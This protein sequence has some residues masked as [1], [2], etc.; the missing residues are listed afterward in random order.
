MIVLHNPDWQ[1][2]GRSSSREGIRATELVHEKGWSKFDLLLGMSERKNGLNTT[3]EYST[4]LFTPATVERIVGHFRTLAESAVA[5]SRT[6]RSRGSRC[7][8]DERARAHLL[9]ALERD[10]GD[11][12]RRPRRSRSCSR[13]RSRARR[14]PT[15]SSFGGERSPSPS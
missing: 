8:L 3:W 2:S 7:S 9:V 4:E 10:A 5:R 11:D 14:T 12:P 1:P 6:G 15:R 13:S